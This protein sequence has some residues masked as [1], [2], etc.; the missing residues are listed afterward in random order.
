[1]KERGIIMQGE[2]VIGI[3]DDRKTQTRRGVKA[4]VNQ[5]MPVNLSK[6]TRHESNI[7]LHGPCINFY[8]ETQ[9]GFNYLGASKY[10]Y[11]QPGDRL[12]V[13]E[14][15]GMD[16]NDFGFPEGQWKN[17]VVYKSDWVN[18]PEWFTHP[19]KPDD[20]YHWGWTPSIFM[21]RWASRITLEIVNV[22]VERVQ[23]I[24]G[25]DAIDEG[26]NALMESGKFTD[27]EFMVEQIA[28]RKYRELWDSINSKRGYGWDTNPYVWVIE[29]KKVKP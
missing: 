2:S 29:F 26:I 14:T 15:W 16:P 19:H 7:N 22:R 11:G 8:D 28:K 4:T 20:K 10:A 1:M 5:G 24:T 3:L 17:F 23:D 21:P 6:A 25:D 9:T 13:R 18:H 12:W 27:P